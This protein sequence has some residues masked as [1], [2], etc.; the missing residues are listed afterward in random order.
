LSRLNTSQIIIFTGTTLGIS[1]FANLLLFLDQT[2]AQTLLA[3]QNQTIDRLQTELE[4]TQ[5]F[6]NEQTNR[7][8][9]LGGQQ[10]ELTEIVG[11]LRTALE[12]LKNEQQQTI[13]TANQT[14]AELSNAKQRISELDQ[15]RQR[16]A[17]E[18]QQANVTIQNQ[19]RAL[20]AALSQQSSPENDALASALSTELTAQFPEISVT[21]TSTGTTSVS[22]P[23]E[24]V[25]INTNL[26]YAPS[27]VT[28]LTAIAQQLGSSPT[29]D[30]LVIGHADA[31]PIVS[32]LV[33][34]YPSNWELS[35][36]RASKV[37]AFLIEQGIEPN[38]LTAAGKSSNRPVRDGN[39]DQSLAINRRIEFQIR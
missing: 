7:M 36:A 3:E 17:V 1:L 12:T 18:I 13:A 38:R 35:A 26:D 23:L 5:Q 34:R 27:A 9:E 29:S 28:I 4:A 24:K 37:V 19:Q 2:D 16:Q 15:Q 39:D 31:R 30:V 8:S 10:S 32:D 33:N 14:K 11:Q 20:R 6:E 21:Q 25:F 22:I